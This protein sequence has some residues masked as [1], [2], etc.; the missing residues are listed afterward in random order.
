MSER[1]ARKQDRLSLLK[2]ALIAVALIVG[3]FG[4]MS[5]SDDL[6][7]QILLGWIGL[8]PNVFYWRWLFRNK[9]GP[10]KL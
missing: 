2:Y 8:A 9:V 7:V 3:W 5:L 1:I 10:P 4:F 6:P